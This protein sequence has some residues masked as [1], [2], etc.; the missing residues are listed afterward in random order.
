MRNLINTQLIHRSVALREI[1]LNNPLMMSFGFVLGLVLGGFPVFNSEMI[2]LSLVVLMSLSLCG[3][4][5]RGLEVKGHLSTTMLALLLTFGLGTGFTVLVAFLFE[6]PLRSGW[7]FEAVV[8]SAVSVIPF[9]FILRG[10]VENS[11]VSSAVIYIVSIGITPLLLLALLGMEMNP[12]SLVTSVV[13]MI[14]LPIIISR[15]VKKVNISSD[16][17]VATINISLMLVAFSVVGAN[18]D[19]FFNDPVLVG[20]LLLV[21]AARIFIPGTLIYLY[22]RYSQVNKSQGVNMVLFS[23]YKNTGMAAAMA[24]SILGTEAALPAAISTPIEILWLVIMSKFLFTRR[25][26]DAEGAE[27]ESPKRSTWRVWIDRCKWRS[28]GKDWNTSM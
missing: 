19:F 8:P 14:F 21:S 20:I 9:S 5:F 15:G 25:Y 12:A 13:I 22:A 1:I 23:T 6:D 24:A 3:M 17:R 27:M 2:T 28:Q 10:N 4:S 18:R 26:F 11:L 7:I 16:V